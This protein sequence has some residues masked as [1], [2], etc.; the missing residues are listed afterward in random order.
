M[1]RRGIELAA[2]LILLALFIILLI[3]AILVLVLQSPRTKIDKVT[4]FKKPQQLSLGSVN[5]AKVIVVVDNYPFKGS[6]L[7]ST[8]GISIYIDLDNTIILFDTGP[9]P[10]ILEHNMKVLGID[11]SRVNFIILSHEHGDHVGG[12]EYVC[13]HAKGAKVIAPMHIPNSI[14][15]I[16]TKFNLE[17][18]EVTNPIK[19]CEGVGVIG[20]LYGP[21]Y[22][23][24]LV[25]NV[26][27]KG[28]ILVVGCAHP[29]IENI[30]K[31]AYNLTGTHVFMVIGGFHL[32]GS[33]TDRLERI[34]NTIINDFNVDKVYPIH[35]T[36]DFARNYFASRLG[37]RY[38]DGHVGLEVVICY[39]GCS[40]GGN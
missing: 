23:V 4:E 6:K 28:L 15:N 25:V 7:I 5:K 27:G 24:S 10:G 36:G 2:T 29:G 3:T 39:F 17:L 35:C 34:V 1:D 14:K 37:S 26:T 38:C 30:I 18:I 16:I 11:P 21:P 32:M 9:D 33:S 19:V 31:Y 12:L 40:G 8:W 20:E 13:K 22:E